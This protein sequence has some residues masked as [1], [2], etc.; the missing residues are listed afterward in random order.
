VLTGPYRYP[1]VSSLV[2]PA[3]VEL[4]LSELLADPGRYEG[5]RLAVRGSVWD[6][7]RVGP[8]RVRVVLG[9][10]GSGQLVCWANRIVRPA[11]G[12]RDI[13]AVIATGTLRREGGAF[14]LDDCEFRAAP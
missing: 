2:A 4:T 11:G 12:P 3:P 5:Q 14:V 1:L 13:D 6:F 8:T 7:E 9:W 10:P